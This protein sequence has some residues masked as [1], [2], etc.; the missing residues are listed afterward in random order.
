MADTSLSDLLELIVKELSTTVDLTEDRSESL[1]IYVTDFAM[2]MP[3][4]LYLQAAPPS[5]TD[6][7]ARLIVNLPSLRDNPPPGRLGRIRISF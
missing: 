6:N 5:S 1:K 7:S 3:A 4:H 2:E